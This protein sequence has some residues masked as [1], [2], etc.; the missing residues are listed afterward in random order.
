[1]ERRL[2]SAARRIRVEAGLDL[3]DIERVSGVSQPT[4]SRFENGI[5]WR[6]E[7]NA[8]VDAYAMACNL[9]PEYIWRLALE[10][11]DEDA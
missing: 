2:G 7:T 5:G 6:R 1:M 4:L 10:E 11:N 3:I 9:T 8:I